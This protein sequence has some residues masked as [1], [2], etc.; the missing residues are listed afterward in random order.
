MKSFFAKILLT[1]LSIVLVLLMLEVNFRIFQLCP[2]RSR[3]F[4]SYSQ[5]ILSN[6]QKLVYELNPSTPGINSDGMRDREYALLKPADTLRI[7]VL[8]DSIAF[9]SGVE[10]NQTFAKVLE[11]KLNQWSVTNKE[12]LKYE[13]LNFSVHGYN[14]NN[15][16]EQLK[17]KADKY[18]PDII[19]LSYCIN[20][21]SVLPQV[22][23]FF[24][25]I[26]DLDKTPYPGFN[27]L[28]RFKII[29]ALASQSDM[30]RFILQRIYLLDSLTDAKKSSY[31]AVID[32]FKEL[33][34]YADSHSSRVVILFNPYLDYEETDSND[35]EM[36]II[37]EIADKNR[38]VFVNMIDSYRH[39]FKH[40]QDLWLKDGRHPITGK[41][42]LCHPNPSGHRAI[43]GELFNAIIQGR[44]P[45]S[46]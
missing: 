35:K 36:N 34:Q 29:R 3:Y 44:V 25:N 13:V 16:I 6:N 15:E 14:I 37:R 17:V 43:A 33:K 46:G 20:D 18:A 24:L 7:A 4:N 5:V 41:Q 32:G 2:N 38:F 23:P 45:D 28:W 19:V 8:G 21:I 9:G 31:Q 30:V 40:Q 39:N 10:M 11:D 22:L 1:I 27:F 12:G 26:P 42:D